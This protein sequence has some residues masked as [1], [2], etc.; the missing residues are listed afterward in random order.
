MRSAHG[1]RFGNISYALGGYSDHKENGKI[2]DGEKDKWRPDWQ[3]VKA[4]IEFAKATGRLQYQQNSYKA[5]LA[6]GL[7]DGLADNSR[8]F[9]RW[10][11]RPPGRSS[12][13][14]PD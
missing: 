10:S 13:N 11:G 7:A 2:V 4:T 14:W 6:D 12:R 3:A 9:S 8:R 5:D 1:R